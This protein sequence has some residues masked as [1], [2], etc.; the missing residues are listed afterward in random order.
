MAAEN[1]QTKHSQLLLSC[2]PKKYCSLPCALGACSYYFLHQ[3]PLHHLP[4]CLLLTCNHA[5]VRNKTMHLKVWC[6]FFS[7]FKQKH[8]N[9]KITILCCQMGT[10]LLKLYPFFLF[11]NGFY[12][13]SHMNARVIFYGC[14]F[15]LPSSSIGVQE[16]HFL[17]FFL[18]SNG[19]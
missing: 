7:H 5:K 11:F 9:E 14:D 12:L 15:R 17:S 1:R 19:K 3:M 16:T 8:V 10:G 18:P 13:A 2:P 6:I 4:C